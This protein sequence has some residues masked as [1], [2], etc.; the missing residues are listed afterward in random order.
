[1]TGETHTAGIRSTFGALFGAML[2]VVAL[3]VGLPVAV[4][5]PESW[6]GAIL[7]LSMAAIGVALVTMHLIRVRRARQ[8]EMRNAS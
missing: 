7:S 8:E 5:F 2:I 1:M 4:N 6:P 3:F